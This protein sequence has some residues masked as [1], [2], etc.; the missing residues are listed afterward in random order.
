MRATMDR[1]A[2]MRAAREPSA[3]WNASGDWF[4]VDLHGRRAPAR[5][6]G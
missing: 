5:G 6:A 1:Y 4:W 3:L 2:A